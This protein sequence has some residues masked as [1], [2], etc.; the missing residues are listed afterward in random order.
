MF[1]LYDNSFK[2]KKNAEIKKEK[3]RCDYYWTAAERNE[4][5]KESELLNKKKKSRKRTKNYNG[6]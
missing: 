2:K 4:E 1:W 6:V 3:Y 5:Y